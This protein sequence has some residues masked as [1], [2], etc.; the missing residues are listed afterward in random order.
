MAYIGR[1]P[2]SGKFEKID[3]SSWTFN[4]SNTLF[5]LGRQ[6]GIA[7]S[8]IVSFNG[9]IQQAGEDYTLQAGGNNI[10]FSTPPDAGDSCFVIQLGDVG[11]TLGTGSISADNLA[12]NLKTFN[13]FTRIF[14]GESDSCSLSF[15][16]S[17]KGALLVLSLIHI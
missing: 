1:E 12:A 8:L 9:V 2:L 15:T 14:Q 17:A 4:S 11:A 5:P 13:E 10:H 16:P 7:E 3:V 6:V